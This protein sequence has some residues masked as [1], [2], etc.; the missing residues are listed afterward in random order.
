MRDPSREAAARSIG[1]NWIRAG[2]AGL[3]WLAI[4]GCDRVSPDAAGPPDLAPGGGLLLGDLRAGH[5]DPEAPHNNPYEVN[6]YALAEGKRAFIAFNCN[7]CHG[8][9]GGGI[10]PPLLDGEWTYGG[11]ADQIYASIMEGRP[12]GMPGFGG[13]L[14]P[15]QAWQLAAYVRSLSG[16]ARMDAAPGR[17]DHLQAK[18]PEQSFDPDPAPAPRPLAPATP[19]EP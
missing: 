9:G 8:L 7:G 18:P 15:D 16:Q 1:R 3:C 2:A 12:N 14:W 6:A 4:A 13:R 10:G 17:T 19:R 11:R 5:G